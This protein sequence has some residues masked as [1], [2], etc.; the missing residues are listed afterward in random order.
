MR[1]VH[2]RHIRGSAK[3]VGALLETLATADDQLWPSA[4]DRA[5]AAL[6][7]GPEVTARWSPRVW[8]L[9]TVRSAVIDRADVRQLETPAAMIA[10]AGLSQVHFSDTFALRLPTGS[11]RDVAH[12][13]RALIA[14]GQP[15]WFGA[16]M[17]VRNRVARGLGLET[18]AG[19]S[20]T[21]PFTLLTR[22]GDTLVV[23]ADDKHLDFRG[24]L[25][26]AG[27]DLQFTTVVHEHNATGRA[28]FAVVKPLHRRIVPALIR[29]T[30]RLECRA[31][32]L[33][34]GE[35]ARARTVRLDGEAASSAPR[36]AD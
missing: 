10:A 29:R 3:R 14:A 32:Q 1:N 28:Y 7:V 4:F 5:E 2:E 17:A 27:D 26:V 13:H 23:G 9:R 33:A 30:A 16:L 6:G 31:E 19:S 11:S 15:A 25:R 22:H 24:V 12:W 35:A 8:L 34:Q 18:A 20:D 36:A 21:S